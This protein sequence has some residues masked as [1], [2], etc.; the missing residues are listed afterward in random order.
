M[1]DRVETILD[2][3]RFNVYSFGKWVGFMVNVPVDVLQSAAESLARSVAAAEG[4]SP[5]ETEALV[6]KA[7][8]RLNADYQYKI[9]LANETPRL[10]GN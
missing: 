2:E 8:E 1:T 5:V 3:M 4:L 9:D 10:K 6:A 7:I